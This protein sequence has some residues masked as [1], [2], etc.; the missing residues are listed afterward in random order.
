VL[1]CSFLGV[2]NRWLR[3]VDAGGVVLPTGEERA[4]AEAE[5]ADRLAAKL[6]AMGVDP[7]AV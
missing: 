4:T 1:E 6:R 3:F 5:R 2:R 7:E